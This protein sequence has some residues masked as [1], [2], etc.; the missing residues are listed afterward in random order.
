MRWLALLLV[1]CGTAPRGA[2]PP[3]PPPPPLRPIPVVTPAQPVR[4]ELAYLDGSLATLAR[5][6][7]DP[8]RFDYRRMLAGALDALEL[9]IAEVI[10]DVVNDQVTVRVGAQERRFAG[11][12][13]SLSE[14]GIRLTEIIHFV[15]AHATGDSELAAV[16]GML[17]TL[18]PHTHLITADELREWQTGLGGRFAGIGVTLGVRTGAGGAD[19]ITAAAILP[20]TPAARGGL[21][22][23]D[24]IV[25]IDGQPTTGFS[26]DEAARRLRGEPGSIVKLGILRGTQ[27]LEVP[28]ERAEITIPI[29]RSRMLDG[30]IGYLHIDRFGADTAVE[31]QQA[32]TA[33]R[34]ARGWVL[35]LRDNTGGYLQQA[36]AATDLFVDTGTIV[37]TVAGGRKHD[38]KDAKPGGDTRAPVVVLVGPQTASSAE[39]MAGALKQLG[40]AVLVGRRT[41]GKGSVQVLVDA[42]RGGKLKITTAEYIAANDISIQA[43]GITPDVELV[44]AEIPRARGAAARLRL[45]PEPPFRE[46]DLGAHLTTQQTVDGDRPLAT[47]RYLAGDDDHELQF[48]RALAAASK[49]TR[50]ASLRAVPAVVARARRQADA[51]IVAAFRRLG[52]DWA[53]GPRGSAPALALSAP[54]TAGATAGEL[55]TLHIA[56]TNTGARPAH[57]VHARA[58]SGDAVLDGLEIA[59]G[60][61]GPRATARGSA[62]VRL[63]RGTASRIARVRWQIGDHAAETQLTIAGGAAPAESARGD[64]TPPQL[65]IDAVPLETTQPTIR[66]AGTATDEQRVGDVYITAANRAAKLDARKVFYRAG[67]KP[68]LAFAAD[69]PLAPGANRIVV[70][71]REH[72]TSRT[73]QTVWVF[74]R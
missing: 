50:A 28:L 36:V 74:R 64:V 71:A 29:V 20:D 22:A 69:I 65:A 43:V 11:D 45:E 67:G 9:E 3:P 4:A 63:P 8:A 44:P 26:I 42:A 58:S 32:M 25:A 59:L 47:V 62:T 6:Y 53:S 60:R 52:I 18:D 23:G 56:V 51:A 31:L 14:L 46:L 73:V 38:I 13:D 61:I 5:K 27:R 24:F 57:R 55:V 15:Q 16:N 10:A 1:A 39:I 17:R 54:P 19:T 2:S 48:A 49:P 68:V 7:V 40:R 33:L 37:A 35:D 30:N 66:I 34:G 41:F 72:A 21:Q 12:V 70:T